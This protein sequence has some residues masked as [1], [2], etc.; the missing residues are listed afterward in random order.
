[1]V[2]NAEPIDWIADQLDKPAFRAAYLLAVDTEREDAL[3]RRDR[4]MIHWCDRERRQI[5]EKYGVV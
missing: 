3:R 5:E 2:E 4:R 1:M